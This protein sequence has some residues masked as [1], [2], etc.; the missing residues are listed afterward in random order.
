MN[1]LNK[2]INIFYKCATLLSDMAHRTMFM[3]IPDDEFDFVAG[4]WA[5]KGAID[6][7]YYGTKS[8]VEEL[9]HY[10]K[11]NEIGKQYVPE[12]INS[13]N[14]ND[15]KNVLLKAKKAYGDRKN[16]DVGFGGNTWRDITDSLIK[17]VDA[18]IE[19]KNTENDS[20][21][22]AAA[23]KKLLMAMNI[24]DGRAHNSGSVY[25]KMV[26][27]EYAENPTINQSEELNKI[28]RLRD[29]SESKNKYDVLREAYPYLDIKLP[30]R[31]IISKIKSEP[32]FFEP[33]QQRTEEHLQKIRKKKL[34]IVLVSDF[35]NA[36]EREVDIIKDQIDQLK[37]LVN[38][39]S[40][41][42]ERLLNNKQ[43]M[44]Q[45]S[46]KIKEVESKIANPNVGVIK[47]IPIYWLNREKTNIKEMSGTDI[48]AH[49]ERIAAAKTFISQI[50]NTAIISVSSVIKK[51][52][53]LGFP[54]TDKTIDEL[55]SA[56]RKYIE[57][58]N[59]TTNEFYEIIKTLRKIK[60]II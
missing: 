6:L 12:K 59:K 10:H 8:V 29:M 16:W 3:F 43:M 50:M 48:S 52:T 35:I 46:V 28:I 47:Y 44:A 51:T 11:Y 39:L 24:F 55:I 41:G 58:C 40:R 36:L 45:F 33:W 37:S 2:S 49:I 57:Y 60:S 26:R 7:I 25:T 30:Y 18:Y 31:D 56:F 21:G 42:R 1:K 14:Y 13:K 9:V 53:S 32:E 17:V 22:Q 20:P 23:I 34:N 19:Y 4:R 54:P 27:Y 15:Y 5:A 38:A